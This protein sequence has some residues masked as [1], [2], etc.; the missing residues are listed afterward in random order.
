[1]SLA[2]ALAPQRR[3]ARLT[4]FPIEWS[5]VAALAVLD[6]LWA[7]RTGFS[8][9]LASLGGRTLILVLIAG[10]LLRV[11]FQQNRLSL[12]AEFFAVSF[13]ATATFGILSYLCCAIDYPLVDKPLLRFDRAIG[14]D[15]LYWFQLLVAHPAIETTLRL[16]YNSLVYQGLY[17]AIFFGLVGDRERLRELFWITFVCG[18]LTAAGSVFLP[19]LGAFDAFGLR[20]LSDYI[21]DMEKLRDGA[22]LHF[23]FGRLTGIV[24]FPSFHTTMALVYCYCFRRTQT[25]GRIVL[26]LNLAMLPA[27]P[28]FGGHYLADMFGGAAVAAIAIVLV[29][30]LTCYARSADEPRLRR[31]AAPVQREAA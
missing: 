23:E 21:P 31:Y 8:L 28:F 11:C 17:A 24:T 27:I 3:L 4:D 5:A 6:L 14:F 20:S 22:D 15:W 16:A 13:A 9:S 25:I 2:P 1:M 10:L 19:A 26:V 29:R 7:R 18:L 12:A 30:M